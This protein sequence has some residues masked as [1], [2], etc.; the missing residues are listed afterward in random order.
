MNAK[1][2]YCLHNLHLTWYALTLQNGYTSEATTERLTSDVYKSLGSWRSRNT[3]AHLYA[4]V[5]SLPGE[6]TKFRMSTDVAMG[7]AR[8]IAHKLTWQT[9]LGY[10]STITQGI[11]LTPES[12]LMVP[13]AGFYFVYSA[14]TFKCQMRSTPLIHLINR[15]HRDRPNADIQQLL[16]S[17]KSECG[18]GGIHTSFLAGVLKLTRNDELSVSLSDVSRS[19]VYRTTLANY[20]GVYSL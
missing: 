19:S 15:Q 2:S 13:S 18:P 1:K 14:V 7:S 10:G 20:F 5:S 16:L 3:A 12:R 17:K 9:Y 11:T 6:N 4:N 8:V